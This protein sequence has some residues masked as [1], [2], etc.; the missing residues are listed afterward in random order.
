MT[1]AINECPVSN[2]TPAEEVLNVVTHGL[3]AVLAVIGAIVLAEAAWTHGTSLHLFTSSVF[4]AS[5][6]LLYTTSTLYH[7]S[8]CLERKARLRVL[9]HCAIFVVIA[10]SYGPF[11]AH[12]VGGWRGYSVL[13]LAWLIALLGSLYKLRSESR[14]SNKSVFAYI[15]Q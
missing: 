10:G 12:V 3:G 4:S 8:R 14:Y 9:D 11:M 2:Q 5:W 1:S 6:I 13:L 15:A 7:F